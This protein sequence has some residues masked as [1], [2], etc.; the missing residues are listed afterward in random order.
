MCEIRVLCI[1][2]S[3]FLSSLFHILL[4]IRAEESALCSSYINIGNA[5]AKMVLIFGATDCTYSMQFAMRTNF[6]CA[7]FRSTYFSI[8]KQNG[9][10]KRISE[11]ILEVCNIKTIY[12]NYFPEKWICNSL[13]FTR[14]YLKLKTHEQFCVF[15]SSACLI[16]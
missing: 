5:F 16:L 7:F 4:S 3:L 12:W 6:W 1:Y 13:D 11:C 8:S 10:H 2:L 15:L 14:F 9:T